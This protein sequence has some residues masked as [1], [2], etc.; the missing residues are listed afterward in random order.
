M[1]AIE[2]LTSKVEEVEWN[3]KKACLDLNTPRL[4][5]PQPIDLENSIK[6]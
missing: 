4:I 1:V 5:N 3:K 6:R 2:C